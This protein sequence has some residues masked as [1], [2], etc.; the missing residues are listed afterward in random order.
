MA[1]AVLFLLVAIALRA[2]SGWWLRPWARINW[3]RGCLIFLSTIFAGLVT[4]MGM[5]E[6][7]ALTYL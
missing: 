3:A 2:T 7:P 5:G 4:P 1:L 6:I